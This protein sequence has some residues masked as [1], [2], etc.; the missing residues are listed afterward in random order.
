MIDFIRKHPLLCSGACGLAFGL[1]Q[2]ALPYI[3]RWTP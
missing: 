3:M 1:V 2:F